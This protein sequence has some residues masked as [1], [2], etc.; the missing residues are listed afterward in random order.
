MEIEDQDITEKF[1]EE[2]R[3]KFKHGIIKSLA[4]SPS[5]SFDVRVMFNPD[6]KE[7]TFVADFGDGLEV[8]VKRSSDPSI[9]AMMINPQNSLTV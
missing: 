1:S 5:K 3:Q 9:I 8:K 6:T 2:C 7:T 4:L